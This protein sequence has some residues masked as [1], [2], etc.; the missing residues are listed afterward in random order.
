[1]PCKRLT[2][3]E[4]NNLLLQT[5]NPR[6]HE[7]NE[8][9]E[10]FCQ[11]C[12]DG[13]NCNYC[14][15]VFTAPRDYG[16]FTVSGANIIE[17]RPSW[18]D[19]ETP[20][21][22]MDLNGTYTVNLNYPYTPEVYRKEETFYAIMI[23]SYGEIYHDTSTPPALWTGGTTTL[24]CDEPNGSKQWAPRTYSSYTANTSLAP[25]YIIN[26]PSPTVTFHDTDPTNKND[27]I[28]SEGVFWRTFDFYTQNRSESV[29]VKYTLCNGPAEDPCQSCQNPPSITGNWTHKSEASHSIL[30][31][32]CDDLCSPPY[33]DGNGCLKPD[34]VC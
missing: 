12:V 5:P 28:S 16:Y 34:A 29:C 11:P 14:S 32:C 19:P 10:N 23:D 18:L 26:G 6:G 22:L 4:Y 2:I 24:T 8:K 25:E 13:S 15:Y 31:Q 33:Y 17:Y 1:M 20:P 30:L 7:T 21:I 27:C 3:A 9:C